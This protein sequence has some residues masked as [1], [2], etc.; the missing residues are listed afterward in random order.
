MRQPYI[1]IAAVGA[2]L[3]QPAYACAAPPAPFDPNRSAYDVAIVG[4]VTNE[5][6]QSGR[7]VANLRTRKVISGRF[8][9]STYAL[10][11][12]VYDGRGMCP[13]PGPHLKK[14][15]IA[16]VYLV[17]SDWPDKSPSPTNR[18]FA[19]GWVLQGAR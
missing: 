9:Y 3:A 15:Q 17:K 11:W 6:G 16:T 14:G 19:K 1:I 2:M 5:V 18:F 4:Q 13:P 8:P 12:F 10:T 7:V